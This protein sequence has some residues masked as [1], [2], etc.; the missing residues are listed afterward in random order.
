MKSLIAQSIEQIERAR[1][2]KYFNVRDAHARITE[3]R[4][5]LGM[6]AEKMIVNIGKANAEVDRLQSQLAALVAPVALAVPSAGVPAGEPVK[7]AVA[8]P[9][10]K[11]LFQISSALG[12]NLSGSLTE[13]EVFTAVEKVAFRA[14]CRFP[15]MATDDEISARGVKRPVIAAGTFASVRVAAARD[16]VAGVLKSK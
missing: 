4:S 1:P 5:E 15:G 12:E 7:P 16:L 6:P 8:R 14:H 11:Q 13:A 10:R 3:L 9:S 2:F